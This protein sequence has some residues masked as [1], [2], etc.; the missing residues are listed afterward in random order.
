MSKRVGIYGIAAV[1]A[2]LAGGVASAQTF[3]AKPIRIVTAEA[4]G[5]LDFS[6]R[7]IANGLTTVLGQQVLIDNRGGGGGSI[8]AEI[9]ARSPA[10][11]YTLFFYSSTAWLLPI[12]R[13][14]G[15]DAI[16]DFSPVILGL[17]APNIVVVPPALPVS[18][19]KDLIALA[20]AQPGKLNYASSGPG[21][22][23]NLAAELFNYLAGTKIVHVPYK[24]GGPAMNDLMAGNVQLM[25]Q[26]AP[27]V[28]PYVQSGRMRALAVTTAERSKLVPG[29]PTVNES[30]PGYEAA[31]IIGLY[32]PVKTPPAVVELLHQK[33]AQVLNR[34]DINEQFFKS[35]QETIDLTGTAA[36]DS[37]KAEIERMGKVIKAAN[38]R[39]D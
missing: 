30:L 12:M 3:P 9:A 37:M 21:S 33:A 6:G 16:R 29:L 35:G 27:G 22:S 32:A 11:G 10:D 19:I 26:S 13:S 23:T 15:Y 1:A 14:V 31:L 2:A 18:S 36:V 8:A 25:I 34:P 38:I 7:V 28:M 17:S 20:K 24:G 4:G 5:A 39:V